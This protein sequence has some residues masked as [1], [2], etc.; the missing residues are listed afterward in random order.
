VVSGTTATITAAASGT[1]APTVQW[2]VSTDGTTWSDDTTDPGN[3]TDTL[4]VTESSANIGD[5]YRAVY[6][7]SVSNPTATPPGPYTIST[8]I[9]N[10]AKPPTSPPTVTANPSN[11]TVTA[12][13]PATFTAA[14]VGSP[15]PSV[16]WQVSTNAGTTWANVAG[17]T[18]TT[19][20]IQPTS[21]TQSGS[22]YRAA[23][24]N[25][26]GT[27]D[28]TAA[29]LTVNPAVAPNTPTVTSVTPS[30]GTAF[31][32]VLITG[33]NFTATRAVDFGSHPTFFLRL[34]SRYILALA[35]PAP[36]GT[37]DITVRTRAG[38][39]TKTPADQFTYRKPA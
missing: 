31:S 30:S 17:A 22:E 32:P 5:A 3:T 14:A 24:T 11:V 33:T 34:S 16:Q 2:Q 4:S 28:S 6:T 35:P 7:N 23:F 25:P 21:T 36:A 37:T 13:A 19:L 38:T 20:T 18:S 10:P 12:P 29:T 39:S 15:P 27:A 9:S 8:A 1:P 26:T